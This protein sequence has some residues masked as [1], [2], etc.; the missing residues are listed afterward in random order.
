MLV[1][2]RWRNVVRG[3]VRHTDGDSHAP[4]D[5]MQITPDTQVAGLATAQPS[6]IKVFQ[7]HHIDFCC[8]GKIPLGEACARAHVDTD[9]VLADLR[10]S[11]TEEEDAS[12]PAGCDLASL[13]DYIQARY[14]RPL[15]DELP[16]LSAMLEKVVSRHGDRLPDVL[17]PLQATFEGAK[18]ELLDHITREDRILFPDIVR[19]EQATSAGVP[20]SWLSR[21]ISVMEHD[22]AGSVKDLRLAPRSVDCPSL[23]S[24]DGFE[25]RAGSGRV[26]PV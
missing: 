12:D 22:H 3:D 13:I 21:P 4:G 5:A 8:G 14:H 2:L 25:R 20:A 11:I 7:R 1:S 18:A 16:R 24:L 26:P 15:R 6:T 10:A 17:F 19:L 23:Y 9:A